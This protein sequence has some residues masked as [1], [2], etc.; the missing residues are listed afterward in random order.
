[1]TAPV[2]LADLAGWD[3]RQ[4]AACAAA[5]PETF[6]PLDL[7][8]TGPAVTAARRICTGCPVRVPCLAD[9]MASESPARRWGITA[10]LTPDERTAL[11][12]GQRPLI[13]PTGAVAA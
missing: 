12:L 5:D 2:H 8:P 4:L 9:V 3:W 7:T 6:Y 11:F 13:G 1:M 10:G